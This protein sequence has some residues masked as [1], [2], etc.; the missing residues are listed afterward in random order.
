MCNLQ[1]STGNNGGRDNE[2]QEICTD[3]PVFKLSKHR[4][5]NDLA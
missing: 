2:C 4:E 3:S 5:P 1:G